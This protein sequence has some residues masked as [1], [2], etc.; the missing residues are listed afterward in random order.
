MHSIPTRD[1][2]G[3]NVRPIQNPS[4]LFCYDTRQLD[5]TI[6]PN[7]KRAKP[8][9]PDDFT[10][11][12]SWARPTRTDVLGVVNPVASSSFTS[13]RAYERLSPSCFTQSKTNE[14]VFGQEQ[15]FRPALT[16]ALNRSKG[17][18]TGSRSARRRNLDLSSTE[19][20]SK[21]IGSLVPEYIRST[22]LSVS[23]SEKDVTGVSSCRQPV[24]S[25][26]PPWFAASGYETISS[27]GHDYLINRKSQL[28]QTYGAASAYN[29]SVSKATI[30][31]PAYEFDIK[32]LSADPLF[33]T[34]SNSLEAELQ[35]PYFGSYLPQYHTRNFRD[36]NETAAIDAPGSSGARSDASTTSAATFTSWPES[37]IGGLE[38]PD[39]S[40]LDLTLIHSENNLA[41]IASDQSCPPSNLMWSPPQPF[42]RAID[43]RNSN[44]AKPLEVVVCE[45]SNAGHMNNQESPFG[46]DEDLTGVA[47]TTTDLDYIH[48]SIA[49][50]SLDMESF[51]NEGKSITLLKDKS[52]I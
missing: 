44:H 3:F 42:A 31:D 35:I 14:D 22:T 45:S 32:P 30:T 15:S 23:R 5:S 19:G 28:E 47:Q 7:P 13:L 20:K 25:E 9:H 6:C 18:M 52:E 37:T 39:W 46:Y 1:A 27:K 21:S 8:S 43:N 41:S 36:I 12:L 40:S 33:A 26:N 2:L 34:E 17:D 11:G 51:T 38:L 48:A 49:H 50:D 29:I 24:P 4:L 16:A 10:K